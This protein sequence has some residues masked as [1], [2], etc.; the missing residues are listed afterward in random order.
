MQNWHFRH[1]NLLSG[2]LATPL[3][4]FIPILSYVKTLLTAV[5]ERMQRMVSICLFVAL[6][7]LALGAR[8][9]PQE[10]AD[11]LFQHNWVRMHAFGVFLV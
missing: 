4:L 11:V 10:K 6:F 5:K 8:M 1:R 9:T 7:A 2:R 3:K